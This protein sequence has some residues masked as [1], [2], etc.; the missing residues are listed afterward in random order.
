MVQSTRFTAIA[1]KLGTNRNISPALRFA[2]RSLIFNPLWQSALLNLTSNLSWIIKVQLQLKRNIKN[3]K[4]GLLMTY[5]R[6]EKLL[7]DL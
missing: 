7:L 1:L 6:Q 4:N 3:T 5:A 2:G